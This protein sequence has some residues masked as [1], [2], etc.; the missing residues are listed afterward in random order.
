MD[1]FLLYLK[2]K[3]KKKRYKVYRI[4]IYRTLFGF[5]INSTMFEFIRSVKMLTMKC[6]LNILNPVTKML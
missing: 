4:W 1:K 6:S 3:Q 2:E 5:H